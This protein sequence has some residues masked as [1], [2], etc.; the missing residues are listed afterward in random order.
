MRGSNQRDVYRYGVSPG[1]VGGHDS[2]TKAAANNVEIPR[3][4]RYGIAQKSPCVTEC[5]RA[6]IS[7]TKVIRPVIDY[8]SRKVTD[9]RATGYCTPRI[10]K[11]HVS[12]SVW[13]ITRRNTIRAGNAAVV[14]RHGLRSWGTAR[15]RSIVDLFN[16]PVDVCYLCVTGSRPTTRNPA[17][18]RKDIKRQLTGSDVRVQCTFR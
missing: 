2:G 6:R 12:G 4:S 1:V 11:G 9:R 18:F 3:R 13:G 10:Y 15:N 5:V 7:R 17:R 8:R 14:Y 16:C